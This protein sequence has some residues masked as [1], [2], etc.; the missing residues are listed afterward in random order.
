MSAQPA[1]L[2]LPFLAAGRGKAPAVGSGN[3]DGGRLSPFMK[4]SF[5]FGAIFCEAEKQHHQ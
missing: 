2:R 1:G 3:A 5:W 4:V